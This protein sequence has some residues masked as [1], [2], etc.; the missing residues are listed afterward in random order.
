MRRRKVSTELSASTPHAGCSRRSQKSASIALAQDQI[1]ETL[2]ASL[3]RWMAPFPCHSTD[4]WHYFLHL[5]P[6][7]H[8][9]PMVRVCRARLF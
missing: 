1:A 6:W 5:L 7:Y 3:D 4:G 2:T 9:L 8:F